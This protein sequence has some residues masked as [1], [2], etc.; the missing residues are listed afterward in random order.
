MTK[1]T[2]N[3]KK[4]IS[5][6][7]VVLA[8]SSTVAFAHEGR[9]GK[10]GRGG[11]GGQFGEQFAKKLNLTDAQKQQISEV[12]KSFHEENKAFFETAGD[13]RRQIREAKEAGDTA[14]LE[15]LKATAK[16]QHAQMK[17]LRDAQKQRIEAV[18]TSEQRAQWQA[19]KAEREAKRAERGNRRKF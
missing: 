18:L 9:G 11:R 2:T 4:W 19:M 12:K 17:Q 3:S 14:R 7:A 5:A 6:A 1:A 16:S 8:L 15:S 10:H 13:T